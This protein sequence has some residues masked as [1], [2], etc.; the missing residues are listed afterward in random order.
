MAL[1]KGELL[2]VEHVERG[3]SY[4]DRTLHSL[5]S[6][7][8]AGSDTLHHRDAGM[9]KQIHNFNAIRTHR[10]TQAYIESAELLVGRDFELT[11]EEYLNT[12][13]ELERNVTAPS[14]ITDS[15]AEFARDINGYHLRV[16]NGAN[17]SYEQKLAIAIYT[18]IQYACPLI[19]KDGAGDGKFIPFF[20]TEAIAKLGLYMENLDQ[21]FSGSM[22]EKHAILLD[23]EGHIMGYLGLEAPLMV[24]SNV[25]LGTERATEDQYYVEKVFGS[26]TFLEIAPAL[27]N[28]LVS[29]ITEIRRLVPRS[30]GEIGNFDRLVIAFLLSDALV[31]M[32]PQLLEEGRKVAIADTELSKIE[33]I[34]DTITGV[35]PASFAEGSEHKPVLSKIGSPYQEILKPRYFPSDTRDRHVSPIAFYISDL[36]TPDLIERRKHIR[37]MLM[38]YSLEKDRDK[39]KLIKGAIFEYVLSTRDM[40]V[41][42]RLIPETV[43]IPVES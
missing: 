27:A 3:D 34:F 2:D 23:K 41:R 16:F 6:I 18:F 8:E 9:L 26:K 10:S 36:F 5:R 7:R 20:D 35:H 21:Y 13:L 15:T 12:L 22:F 1:L 28:E 38:Q 11:S 37:D 4:S 32:V 24:N 31:E 40:M 19:D 29:S 30:N 39:K 42:T 17:L 25:T 33:V 14:F 43:N